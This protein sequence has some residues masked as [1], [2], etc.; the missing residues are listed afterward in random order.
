MPPESHSDTWSGISRD[1]FG[2]GVDGVD[3]PCRTS[4]EDS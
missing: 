3:V 4:A 2:V 1:G